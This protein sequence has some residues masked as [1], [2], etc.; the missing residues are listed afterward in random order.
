MQL[1]ANEEVI[2][3]TEAKDE[4]SIDACEVESLVE[5]E[6]FYCPVE[7]CPKHVSGYASKSGLTKHINS[8]HPDL[9]E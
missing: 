6:R 7:D 5:T 8:A 4:E 1:E 3:E 9:Q 2:V